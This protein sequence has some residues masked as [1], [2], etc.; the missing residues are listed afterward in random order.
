V[1][2]SGVTSLAFLPPYCRDLYSTLSRRFSSAR[3]FS[4]FESQWEADSSSSLQSLS[5]SLPTSEDE[6]DPAF[7]DDLARC[8]GDQRQRRLA[9]C[10]MF[11]S[12]IPC[13][14]MYAK[15]WKA[16]LASLSDGRKQERRLQT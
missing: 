14:A 7:S 4:S 12:A 11:A 10:S 1:I 16:L 13:S 9:V 3:S 5:L 6:L 15:S 8:G 2:A